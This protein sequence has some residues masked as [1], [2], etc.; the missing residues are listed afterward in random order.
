MITRGQLKQFDDLTGEDFERHPVWIS[1]RSV[2]YGEPWYEET[3]EETFRP[4]NGNLPADGSK[5][6]LLVR[7]IL[8]LS[9]GTWYPGF[10]TP[11]ESEGDLATQQPQIFAGNRRFGFWG[12]IVGIPVADREALYGALARKQDAIFPIRFTADANLATGVLTG[13]VAGFYR[14]DVRGIQVEH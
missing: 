10:V 14:Q 8:E 1:C 5:G 4:W 6:L 3:D 12:G 2:D 11:A 13:T 9:D 7:A